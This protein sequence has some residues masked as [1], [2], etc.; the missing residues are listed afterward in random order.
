LWL[1]QLNL[2]KDRRYDAAYYRGVE[3]KGTAQG[4]GMFIIA[5][6]VRKL[7]LPVF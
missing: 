5:F 1:S 6:P 2:G 4:G 7:L 3:Q